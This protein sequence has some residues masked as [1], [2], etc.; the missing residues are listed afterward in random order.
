EIVRNE[1]T[2]STSTLDEL[3]Q[4]AASTGELAPQIEV[5]TLVIQGK[6][7]TSVRCQDTR[8]LVDRMNA[9]NTEY[10]EVD[11]GHMLVAHSG[12]AWEEVRD[13]ILNFVN[14]RNA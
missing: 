7:D 11:A 4:L 6:T 14:G 12:N 9:E 5:P 8:A 10:V 3:R 13:L 2:L 1:I